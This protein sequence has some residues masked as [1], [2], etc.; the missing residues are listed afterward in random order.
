MD[1]NKK[2][3]LNDKPRQGMFVGSSFS[4]LRIILSSGSKYINNSENYIV[5]YIEPLTSLKFLF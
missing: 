1:C 2:D 4:Q 3:N 5:H